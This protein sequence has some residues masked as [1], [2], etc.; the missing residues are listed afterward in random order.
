[1]FGKFSKLSVD[2]FLSI[3]QLDSFDFEGTKLFAIP[4]F[5]VQDSKN[6]YYMIGKLEKE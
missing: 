2:K 1:L 6:A 4:D 3:D 5:A